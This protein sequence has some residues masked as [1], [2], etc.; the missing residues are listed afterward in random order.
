MCNG[1]MHRLKNHTYV[2]LFDRKTKG[3][4]TENFATC[5]KC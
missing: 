3:S 1:S 2:M 4:C 5:A